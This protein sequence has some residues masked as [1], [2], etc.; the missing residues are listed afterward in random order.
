ME[1]ELMMLMHA[2]SILMRVIMRSWKKLC[3]DPIFSLVIIS[4]QRLEKKMD[5]LAK[6][7]TMMQ[8]ERLMTWSRI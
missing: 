2:S 1:A 3:R 6:D 5:S 8:V 4:K 7:S